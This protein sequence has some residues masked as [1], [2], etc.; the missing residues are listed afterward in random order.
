MLVTLPHVVEAVGE[1]ASNAY[2]FSSQVD[3][4]RRVAADRE[5]PPRKFSLHFRDI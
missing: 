3:D 1:Y 5:L 2:S 4:I